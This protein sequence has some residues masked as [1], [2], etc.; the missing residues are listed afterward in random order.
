MMYEKR[1]LFLDE[2]HLESFGEN[3]ARGLKPVGTGAGKQDALAL[4]RALRS[5]ERL[6][7]TLSR[8]SP[9]PEPAGALRWLEDNHYL[10]RREGQAALRG[11]E[12]SGR[13]RFAAGGSLVSLLAAALLRTGRGGFTEA[14]LS[15]FLRGT[16]KSLILERD[17]LALLP[18]A[19]K[20]AAIEALETLY[21]EIARGEAPEDGE[22]LAGALISALRE[23]GGRD[24]SDLLE[25]A[26]LTE[27]ILRADP[28]GIYGKMAKATRD[29]YR[30]RLASLAA[31]RGIP[32]HTAAR[33]I[34]AMAEGAEGQRAHVGYWIFTAPMGD[35]PKTRSGAG[36][37]TANLLLTL[38][39]SL[40]AGFAT[41]SAAA[42]GLLLLPI[43]QLVQQ[44]LDCLL[45]RLLP[46]A[47]V[48]RMD[49][50]GGVP[51]EGKA[52]CVLSALLT[53]PESGEALGRALERIR[54]LNRD[55]GKNVVYALLADLPEADTES[56][57]QDEALLLAARE[58]IERRNRNG[59]Y[60]LLTRPRH[61]NADGVRVG[62]E[63]K[64]GALLETMRLLRGEPC[65]VAVAAGNAE[66]LRD[67]RYLI[68][69]DSDTVTAPGAVGELIGAMLHPL[70]RPAVDEA[71]G[72]VT[73]G[74]GIL[75]PR[76]GIRLPDARRSD[77]SRIFAGQGG[78]DPYGGACSEL[79][80][81]LTG[82]SVFTGKG[83]LEI[84][85]YLKCMGQRVPEGILLSHD[86]V[87]GAFLRCG[88]VGEVEVCDGFPGG[89]LPFW[90]RMERW[91]RGDWQN[92]RW[93][94]RPGRA[95]PSAERWR[96][97]DALRRSLLPP[98]TLAALLAGFLSE[99]H[100]LTLAAAAAALALVSELLLSAAGALL[101]RGGQQQYRSRLFVGVT[102]GFA[103]GFLRLLLLPGEAWF[104]LTAALRALWRMAVTKRRLL[105]WQTAAQSEG[106]GFGACCRALWAPTALGLGLIFLSPFVIGKTAGLLWL[107]SP[108][109]AWLLSL[110]AEA[111]PTL[112]P[113]EQAYLLGCARDT[114]R[115]FDR[116]LRPED[117]WLP[118]DNVQSMPPLG[119]T[120]RS[121]P[122]NMGFGLLSVLTALDLG[123]IPP[124]TGLERLERCIGAIED[125]PKW[126]GHPF[127]W[128]DTETG[129]PMTPRFVSTVDNGNLCACLITAQ[130][131]L[132]E[133]GAPEL[134][135]R[136]GALAEAMD[137]SLL[138]DEKRELLYIG[139]EP[140][141]VT[142]P[143][144]HYDLLA[145]EARLTAF[146]AVSRGDVPKALWRRMSRAQLASGPYRGMASWT[147]TMFEYLM[148]ELLLP[149]ERS[150]LLWETARFCLRVQRRRVRGEPGL[151]WGISESAYRSLDP[152]MSY[153]YKA[154][155]C[156]G[157]ALKP[158]MDEELVLSPYSSFLALSV[159]PH[160]AVANLKALQGLGMRGPMGFWEALDC[161]PARVGQGQ[162][163]P[164]RSVM[165]H[166]A[167]M[168]LAA[169]DNALRDGILQKRFLRDPA[170]GA[171][172]G[173]LQER[174]PVGAPVLKRP[175][176]AQPVRPAGQVPWEDRGSGPDPLHPRCCMLAS[177]TCSLLVTDGGLTRLRWGA[178]A[179]YV[180]PVSPTAREKGV[181]LFLRTEDGA[182]LSLLPGEGQGRCSHH[183]AFD[184]AVLTC[185]AA[186]L[187]YETRISLPENVVGER[188]E[189]TIRPCG[190]AAAKPRELFLRFRPL[191]GREE[192][193]RSHPAFWGLGISA[194]AENG[195]LLLRRLAR[196]STR[197][198]WM[199]FAA[200]LPCRFELTPGADS[201]RAHR[202]I[203]A[204]GRERFLTDPLVTVRA[205]L[206]E[207]AGGTLKLRFAL[208]LAYTPEDALQSAEEI[209]R[210]EERS[211]L[212]RLAAEL[213]G[214]SRAD[215]EAAN[216]WLPALCFPAAPGGSVRQEELWPFGISGDLP[217]LCAR[218]GGEA[219]LSAAKKH[220][221]AHL[222]LSGCGCDF[223][224]VLLT[225]D[226][227]GYHRPI[228][229]ALTDALR[230][231]GGELLRDAKGGVH[232]I[233]DDAQA[234]P[235][236]RAAALCLPAAEGSDRPQAQK[237]GEGLP[238]LPNRP[239]L[240]PLQ[241]IPAWE[242]GKGLE[243]RF[244]VNHSLPP[245][246]WQHVLAGE[247]LGFLAT[248]CGT[249]HLWLDNARER[250]LTPWLCRP[251]ETE[252]P[253]RLLL[254]GNGT[255]VSAFAE[256]RDTACCVRFAPGTAV[257]EKRIGSA[258]LRTTA[259]VP[260]RGAVRILLLE[261]EGEI[262]AGL[263][264]RW[265]MD[266]LLGSRTEDARY[267]LVQ[268]TEGGMTAASERGG[269]LR[270]SALTGAPILQRRQGCGGEPAFH[271]RME[272]RQRMALVCGCGNPEVLRELT[273]VS[274]AD[275][276]LEETRRFWME[277]V[278]GLRLASGS[279]ALD[280][281]M[282][283][284]IICQT[285]AGRLLGRCSIYQSGGA[286]GF[287]DQL[288]DTVN[289]LAIDPGLARAQILRCCG[290]Q[291]AEGDVQHW[292]HE[293]ET[294]CRGIRTR[295]SDDLLW[296]PWALCEYAE[297]TGDTGLCQ[298]QVPYLISPPLAP[299]ER[300]R[301]EAAAQSGETDSV[302]GHC[303]RA[304]ALVLRRGRGSHGLLR[305]GSGDWN[306]GMDAVAG[307]SEW[308]T[309]FFLCVADR[310]NRLYVRLLSKPA[311]AESELAALADAANGAWDGDHF[312]RGYYG[313]GAPLGG[314]RCA[315]CRID[316]VAQSWAA[317]CPRADP[318]KVSVALTAAAE[319]LFDRERG[320]VKLFDPP[321]AGIEAPGY[322]RCYGPGFREN[323]G[324]YT[325]GALWLV[326]AL[327]GADRR[328]AA[329]RMLSALLPASKDTGTYLCEP[330]VLAADVYSAPGHEGEGGWSWYTGS[331]GWM[332]R[333]V[334]EE[335]LG[336]HMRNGRLVICPRLPPGM[337]D[338]RIRFG[339]RDI[340]IRG[341]EISVDG[342]P[343]RGEELPFSPLG[344]SGIL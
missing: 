209:L 85:T 191:L 313:D 304:L 150:S 101:R 320:I 94:F 33:Q 26:D 202:R 66:A 251:Y 332:L 21:R 162:R 215:A 183:F 14:R 39:L 65:G 166:H 242:Y 167:G 217:I 315:E 1:G 74:H 89:I 175:P 58:A 34:L 233:E 189:I 305:F 52:L 210:T 344:K 23:L 185:S 322:I 25:R 239:L 2:A 98:A 180:S 121:S 141:A 55:A 115:Y 128:Y 255:C 70:N 178:V 301:C 211:A 207:S 151:P 117:H 169:A 10:I 325:H 327:M 53:S 257:W 138:Y 324:Q 248:D 5:L 300:D 62:W 294:G 213:L 250:Q 182:V 30:Q 126:R 174:V 4:R 9:A 302:L 46:P 144:A 29:A 280:R 335:L 79:H 100:G 205:D 77:F 266:L 235:I 16:Q 145:S 7:A 44:T 114:W 132:T 119:P 299:E 309:W 219:D 260:P 308:L 269:G 19:L 288:Q 67:I 298:A 13:L 165:A 231:A 31:Q 42:A 291:Y 163:R 83:I 35:P 278:G 214:M 312:L 212:P 129:L 160:A 116:Y 190:E 139:R 156:A 290:R 328:E 120:R 226:G 86:A 22:A 8:Q 193:Y 338:V 18:D 275:A 127:N 330:F 281:L 134:A 258:L 36:Y 336:L 227:A 87:E 173:L 187:E 168:S 68:E 224:L 97:F 201:G 331:A 112:S 285:L 57:A 203:F 199:C 37:I 342:L 204:E 254:E 218:C 154:H 184:R 102:G 20:A 113:E 28:A 256:P 143:K 152:G 95:L 24:L 11:L 106:S 122:T 124:E 195:S 80:M 103:R 319:R 63:R 311:V 343:Y 179:P 318:E 296:L 75:A 247:H 321:F 340:R 146:L 110:P 181:E 334:T 283:G 310:F 289:L 262:P 38:F 140:E 125:L 198:L 78:T 136:A 253:E 229:T 47:H 314:D 90:R 279:E 286:F 142:P 246:A 188:R 329:F 238:P 295:C 265:E 69:L 135:R 222:F 92:L 186:G 72:I 282:N 307:E 149:P 27:Q 263:T 249:G 177:Q 59:E 232:I 64:R 71:R 50:S 225:R 105:Q 111:E 49:V 51:P 12:H 276:A 240:P 91:V 241:E 216:G 109:T 206:P 316:S 194:R 221:D 148:P 107:F 293:E 147:G 155:G 244:Y 196:G 81:D 172:R 337:D 284:W 99:N 228:R 170:M 208:G 164:V 108:L 306:D 104:S 230:R 45:L 161:T 297:K 153:R 171:Y 61:K 176:P 73:A 200:S 268:P 271:L 157:L 17:E 261:W 243:F 88:F 220:M 6:H 82:R 41:G 341:S 272:P 277:R 326:M 3:F 333:T 274:A 252:G 84:D 236:L 237:I 317:F 303:A 273:H 76:V 192:D 264:L 60:V 158:G 245:R 133:L 96:L 118:P 159:L 43:S 130:Q 223:D 15:L 270:F 123:F 287:R 40:A 137:F 323:G 48:P 259:F 131:G 234:A 339:G 32:Q 292:W 197:E 54:L 93:L 56:T 267:C